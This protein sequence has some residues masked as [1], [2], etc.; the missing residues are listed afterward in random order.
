MAMKFHR[1]RIRMNS[2]LKARRGHALSGDL[3]W[4]VMGWVAVGGWEASKEYRTT[5]GTEF[6]ETKRRERNSS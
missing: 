6:T 5:E 2:E 1:V 3:V 4:G